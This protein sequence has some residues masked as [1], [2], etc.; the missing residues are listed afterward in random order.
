MRRLLPSPHR[1]VFLIGAV[2]FLVTY[3]VQA[4]TWGDSACGPARAINRT[5]GVDFVLGS[6]IDRSKDHD[7][8][9]GHFAGTA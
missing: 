5:R 1:D 6:S 2:T 3:A 4:W 8:R 9:A 7:D